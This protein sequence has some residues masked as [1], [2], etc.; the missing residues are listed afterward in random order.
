MPKLVS[1]TELN[2]LCVSMD[3]NVYECVSSFNS[4]HCVMAETKI[5]IVGTITPPKGTNGGY[6]YTA[7]RNN[8]YGYIDAAR[9]TNLK[10]LKNKLNG[11]DLTD[12]QKTQIVGEIKD[13]LREQ[14]IAFLDIM[15]KAI[16]KKGSYK[17]SD[18]AAYTL[19]NSTFQN[20]PQGAK[21]ICNSRLAEAGF[22]QIAS[23]LDIDL[24]SVYCPQR[25]PYIKIKE[26]WILELRKV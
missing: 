11:S 3:K 6:F 25:N 22:K 13:V 15:D 7:P 20:I 17:D 24:T 16:R 23:E 19:D 5:I 1:V 4:Q 26:K 8:I 10:E 18:I 14:Q 2:N 12:L 21:I 9:G